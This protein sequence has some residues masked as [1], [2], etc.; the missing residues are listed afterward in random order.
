MLQS[1]IPRKI[2]VIK[3]SCCKFSIYWVGVN[4]K[5]NVFN[6]LYVCAHNKNIYMQREPNGIDCSVI[7]EVL[8][9]ICPKFKSWKSKYALLIDYHKLNCLI[10]SILNIQSSFRTG[11]TSFCTCYGYYIADNSVYSAHVLFTYSHFRINPQY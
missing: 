8:D 9:C 11:K 6:V 2:C 1:N 4:T 10:L 3:L 7:W 5:F